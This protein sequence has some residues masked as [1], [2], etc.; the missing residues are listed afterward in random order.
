MVRLKE[1]MKPKNWD[2]SSIIAGL[3]WIGI[4][5]GASTI[6]QGHKTV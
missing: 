2:I 6:K 5:S 1:N 4:I 3:D